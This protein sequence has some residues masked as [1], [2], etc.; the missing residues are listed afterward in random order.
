MG[1]PLSMYPD[2]RFVSAVVLNFQVKRSAMRNYSRPYAA[3]LAC[4]Q[5]AL[6]CS[7]IF[8]MC[9]GGVGCSIGQKTTT[10]ALQTTPSSIPAGT[11]AFVFT[12]YISHNNG[13]FAGA[14]W[15]LTSN[16]TACTPGC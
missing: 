16:G 14:K 11:Q 10:L 8:L 12:A 9:A 6:A 13:N 2:A 4:V 1:M 5:R 15:T 3:T 7:V